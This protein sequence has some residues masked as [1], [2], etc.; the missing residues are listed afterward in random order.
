MTNGTF[1]QKADIKGIIPIGGVQK[2]GKLSFDEE[3]VGK[4][5]EQNQNV[6]YLYKLDWKRI[7][8]NPISAF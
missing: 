8:S 4:E 5:N 7:F 6:F 1:C 2:R 3:R